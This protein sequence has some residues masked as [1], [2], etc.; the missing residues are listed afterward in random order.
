MIIATANRKFVNCAFA[1]NV[2]YLV[3]NDRH[4]NIL[5]TTGFPK[6]NLL[7]IDEF[8]AVLLNS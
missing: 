1:A 3:S 5:K 8:M 7:K 4:F 6:I 2:H